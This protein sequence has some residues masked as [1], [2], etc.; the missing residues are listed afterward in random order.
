MS[1][2]AKILNGIAEV[3]E[4]VL[5]LIDS[6]KGPAAAAVL[7]A[8]QRLIADAA[9]LAAGP[10]D[11]ATLEALRGKVDKHCDET[12]ARLRSAG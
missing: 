2:A 6:K 9:T 8:L 10:E 7:D 4:R 12:L 1:G 11:A 5:P 3:A